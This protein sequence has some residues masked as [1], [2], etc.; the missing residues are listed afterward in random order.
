MAAVFVDDYIRAAIKSPD[1]TTLQS[2]GRATLHTVHGLFLPSDRSG[3]AGDKDPIST[4]KL[5]AGNA[6]WA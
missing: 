3:H 1:G 4:K 2:K 5:E 6:C